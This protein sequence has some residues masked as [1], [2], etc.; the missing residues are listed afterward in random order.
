MELSVRYDE[1]VVLGQK[2]KDSVHWRQ[3]IIS[4]VCLR[5]SLT[6]VGNLAPAYNNEVSVRRELIEFFTLVN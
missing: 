1:I 2:K 6:F 3:S 4:E 5:Q